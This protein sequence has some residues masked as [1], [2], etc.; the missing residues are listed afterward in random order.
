MRVVAAELLLPPPAPPP[1]LPSPPPMPQ[2]LL[3][4]FRVATDVAAAA[5]VAVVGIVSTGNC[6]GCDCSVAAGVIVPPIGG[7]NL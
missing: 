5:S 4:V 3:P 6:N 2:L 1:P 7:C